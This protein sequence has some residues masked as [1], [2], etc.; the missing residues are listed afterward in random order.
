MNVVNAQFWRPIFVTFP[1]IDP[2][3]EELRAW[4]EAVLSRAGL[5]HVSNWGP[6]VFPVVRV[7]FH[8]FPAVSA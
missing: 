8:F 1:G 7:P 6:S 3:W 2:K 5:L 4:L